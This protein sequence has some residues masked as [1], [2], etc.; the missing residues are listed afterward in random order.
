MAAELE[1]GIPKTKVGTRV[2]AVTV[3]LAASGAAMPSADPLPNSS[4][5]F[6]QRLASL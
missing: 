6:D 5:D 2:V 1:P 4:G 3:L